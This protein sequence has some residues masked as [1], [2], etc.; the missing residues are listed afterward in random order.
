M[1]I[2]ILGIGNVLMGDE[3]IG[4]CAINYLEKHT[5]PSNVRLLDGGTGG[6]HLLEY[7]QE[8]KKIIMIDAT[9]DGSEPGTLKVIKP[10][11]STDFPKALSAHDIGLKDL[12]ES[13]ALLGSLPEIHLI[14]ITIAKIQ[15][16]TMDLSPEINATLPLIHKK[17]NE[18]LSLI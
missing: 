18:I 9:M 8:Y 17:V 11:F 2:L 5:F 12:V 14:T 7:L 3:G 13:A 1:D 15:P 16:M 6:F 4:V 10:R